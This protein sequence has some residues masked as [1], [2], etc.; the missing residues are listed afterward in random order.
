MYPSCK[1]SMQ[2]EQFDVANT[3]ENERFELQNAK[4]TIEM[5]ASSSKMLQIER[6]TDRTNGQNRKSIKANNSGPGI[7]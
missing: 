1:K 6:N 5:A 7:Y 2:H 4:N 3:M